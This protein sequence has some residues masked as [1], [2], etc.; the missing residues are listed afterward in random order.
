MAEL[1]RPLLGSGRCQGWHLPTHN[2]RRSDLEDM[3]YIKFEEVLR[4]M[5]DP[6][7]VRRKTYTK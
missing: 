4:L 2:I 5:H 3:A 7:R 1:G 6:H